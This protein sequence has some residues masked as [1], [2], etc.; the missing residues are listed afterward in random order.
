MASFNLES[1][2]ADKFEK[3]VEGFW[4][5]GLSLS[6]ARKQPLQ[7]LVETGEV[8]RSGSVSQAQ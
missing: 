2:L 8:K 6:D 3:A 5:K 4:V 1:E 7:G